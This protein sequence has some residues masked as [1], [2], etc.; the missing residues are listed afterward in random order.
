MMKKVLILILSLLMVISF[1]ACGEYVPPSEGSGGNIGTGD[2]SSGNNNGNGSNTKPDDDVGSGP[3]DEEV[4]NSPFTVTLKKDGRVFTNTEGVKAQWT[5]KFDAYDADFVDGVA[6]LQ[7][8]DGEYHVTLSATPRSGNIQYTYDPNIYTVNNRKRNIEIELFEVAKP[9]KGSGTKSNMYE[10]RK[11]GIYRVTLTSRSQEIWYWFYPLSSGKY[12]IT[13]W[14][15]TTADI[16][17]P[18]ATPYNGNVVSGVFVPDREVD[19]GGAVGTYT[20]NFRMETS[21][22][23]DELPNGKVFTVSAD[24]VGNKYPVTVDF[25][26]KYEDEYTREDGGY[27]VYAEGPFYTGG[28]PTGTWKYIYA[29]TNG[30]LR[31][32]LVKLN[33]QDHYYHLYDET[34]YASTGGYGPLLFAKLTQDNE[35]FQT[36]SLTG[37]RYNMG[38]NW[39]YLNGGMI[40]CVVDGYDYATMITATRDSG[41]IYHDAYGAHCNNDGAHPV[42]EEIKTFLQG[43]ASRE[44]YFDDGEGWA[45]NKR[46]NGNVSLKS[47]EYDQWL[48]ACGYYNAR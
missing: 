10:V 40:S 2:S 18:R 25:V 3:S 5:G 7:G 30:I 12:S 35:V 21:F 38:F 39:N 45:E 16:V 20:K 24:S 33:P 13:S 36:V 32:D 19:R 23:W 1:A 26:I 46:L 34:A 42:T 48:F 43:F 44:W 37:V 11:E 29:D 28:T 22:N 31:G 27:P 17:N 41:G 6:S 14:V 4:D 8:L 9:N 15:D 47:A